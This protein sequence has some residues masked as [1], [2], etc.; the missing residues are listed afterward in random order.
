MLKRY[1]NSA[2]FSISLGPNISE[3]RSPAAVCGTRRGSR[4]LALP[5]NLANR[6]GAAP[7]REQAVDASPEWRIGTPGQNRTE[8]N[9]TEQRMKK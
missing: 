5:A 6:P 2:G 9:I 8:Q 4:C 7:R 1:L 3:L